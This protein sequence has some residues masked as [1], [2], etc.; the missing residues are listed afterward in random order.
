MEVPFG[1]G[2]QPIPIDVA[3]EAI[4]REIE[5]EP[6]FLPRS[7]EPE[8]GEWLLMTAKLIGA[9]SILEIGTF[10]G[11]TTC[12]L[13][14]SG[15]KVTTVDIK[16][17][18]YSLVKD[19]ADK[20]NLYTFHEMESLEFLRKCRD[21]HQGFDLIF[22]DGDHEQSYVMKELL[23]INHILAQNTLCVLHDVLSDNCPGV[24]QALNEYRKAYDVDYVVLNT[25]RGCG[26][27]LI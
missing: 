22:I 2:D 11:Y 13:V 9:R 5:K 19:M 16:D 1:G 17:Q 23:L 27:A 8:V 21:V 20:Y 3:M 15:A 24:M 14:S 7:S 4:R 6:D 10:K 18:R 25:S 12:K 26:L